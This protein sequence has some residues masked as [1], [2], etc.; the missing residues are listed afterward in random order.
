MRNPSA[1]IIENA[2]HEPS[3]PGAASEYVSWCV[4]FCFMFHATC[5]TIK[6]ATYCKSSLHCVSRAENYADS[7]DAG[8]EVWT[9]LPDD[10]EAPLENDTVNDIAP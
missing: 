4:G 7:V 1:L 10:D 5:N 3:P 8:A 2:M 9:P 6:C